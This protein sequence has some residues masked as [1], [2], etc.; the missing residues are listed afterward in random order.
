MNWAELAVLVSWC[1]LKSSHDFLHTFSRA[2]YPEWGVKTGFTFA[3]QFFMLISDGLGGER[4]EKSELLLIFM[5]IACKTAD[6]F[7]SWIYS[8]Y[9][10]NICFLSSVCK[11]PDKDQI[12]WEGHKIW[13][14]ISLEFNVY[15]L[16]KCQ[17]QV[18]FGNF[19]A[20]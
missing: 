16:S 19:V 14:N 20:L 7:D 13:L 8:K 11:I 3:L 18:E 1:I 2:L 6:N 12:F 10:Y 15:I 17:I 4:Y 5:K 9:I